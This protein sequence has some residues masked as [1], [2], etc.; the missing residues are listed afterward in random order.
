MSA[1]VMLEMGYIYGQTQ[2]PEEGLAAYRRALARAVKYKTQRNYKAAA[3]RGIGF[4]LIELRRFDEAETALRESLETEP[5]NHVALNEIAYIQDL[6]K[7][8]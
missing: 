5:G 8:K 3:L 1:N 4:N 7:K 6:R 2:R